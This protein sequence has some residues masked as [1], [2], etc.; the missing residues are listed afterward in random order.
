[1][2]KDV[3]GM[4]LHDR[5]GPSTPEQTEGHKGSFHQLVPGYLL[6]DTAAA[7]LFMADGSISAS[8]LSPIEKVIHRTAV[9]E[10]TSSDHRQKFAHRTTN[11]IYSK[12][13]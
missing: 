11:R 13:L 10:K 9:S 3:K 8:G 7:W 1:M 12:H 4:Q 6:H 5:V 2:E